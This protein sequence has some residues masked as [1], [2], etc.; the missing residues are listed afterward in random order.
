[1]DKRF[2]TASNSLAVSAFIRAS[3]FLNNASLL[4]KAKKA[5]DFMLQN[6]YYPGRGVFHYSNDGEAR[7]IG[8]LE[9]N[10][11][12]SKM[13]L[14]LYQLSGDESYLGKA[15]DVA[16]F[17]INNLKDVVAGAYHDSLHHAESS[18]KLRLP[19]KS[20]DDNALAAR[21]MIRL[22]YLTGKEKYLREATGTL[23]LFSGS[24]LNY[25][26]LSASYGLACSEFFMQPLKAIIVGKGSDQRTT[27]LIREANVIPDKW[28][29]I[30]VIDEDKEDISK[31]GVVRAEK[32]ALYFIKEALISAPVTQADKVMT[33]LEKF[34]KALMKSKG[35]EA[36][37]Q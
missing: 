5:A 16:D 19:V 20:M 14:D 31:I 15:E 18:G 8:I 30:K 33:Q 23:N 24:Y 1:V 10:A 36:M 17:I 28:I 12:F 35:P 34:K 11:L 25:G 21:V 7:L 3:I 9:D 22:Y 6:M 27:A 2:F 37:R 32:P 29:I 4:E 26:V 13:L